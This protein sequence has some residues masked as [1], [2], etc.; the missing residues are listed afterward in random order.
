MPGKCALKRDPRT[1]QAGLRNAPK[2][3]LVSTQNKGFEQRNATYRPTFVGT[4]RMSNICSSA[5]GLA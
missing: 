5:H 3:P 1:L 2:K 4:V